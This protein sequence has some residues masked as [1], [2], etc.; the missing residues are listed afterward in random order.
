MAKKK[1]LSRQRRWQIRMREEGRCPMCGSP[2]EEGYKSGLCKKHRLVNRNRQRE[3]KL[4]D[5]EI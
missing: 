1:T 5:V 2:S 3:R 4:K